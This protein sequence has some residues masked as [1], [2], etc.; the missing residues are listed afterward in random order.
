M[1][2]S[3]QKGVVFIWCVFIGLNGVWFE[4]AFP[5]QVS[6]VVCAAC[7]RQ[8]P[9]A[10]ACHSFAVGFV[11]FSVAPRNIVDGIVS[12]GLWFFRRSRKKHKP[13]QNGV[14]R[15]RRPMRMKLSGLPLCKAGDWGLQT[16]EQCFCFGFF[17]ASPPRLWPLAQMYKALYSA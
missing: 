17:A 12:W 11:V 2:V 9:H 10:T 13:H 8:K 6:P 4:D 15:G 16:P 7:P 3:W 1:V 5:Q 14:A